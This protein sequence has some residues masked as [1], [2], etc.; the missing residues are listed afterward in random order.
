[1]R[2]V[3]QWPRPWPFRWPLIPLMDGL[4]HGICLGLVESAHLSG[5]ALS[6]LVWSR[7]VWPSW[8]R[9]FVYPRS[10]LCKPCLRCCSK[11]V[12]RASLAT[13]RCLCLNF[14]SQPPLCFSKPAPRATR[15]A[16]SAT[17][18]SE[19]PNMESGGREN[20]GFCKNVTDT[21]IFRFPRSA[22]CCGVYKIS[23]ASQEYPIEHP[24]EQKQR[25]IWGCNNRKLRRSS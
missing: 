2:G 1:M 8:D 6:C 24:I 20:R 19:S 14:P 3:R 5:T 10:G 22:R 23:F 17:M 11:A 7:D 4:S 18:A 16:A 12:F 15:L 13:T 9:E 21:L 25:K